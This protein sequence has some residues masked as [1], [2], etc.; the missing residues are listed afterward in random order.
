MSPNT[1]LIARNGEAIKTST[2]VVASPVR[3]SHTRMTTTTM[4]PIITLLKTLT[5]A[6]ASSRVYPTDKHF[7]CESTCALDQEYFINIIYKWIDIIDI[8]DAPIKPD[9]LKDKLLDIKEEFEI[10]CEEE[11]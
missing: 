1:K 4:N 3:S 10:L 11:I 2:V 6:K 8:K 5:T 7:L 9:Y